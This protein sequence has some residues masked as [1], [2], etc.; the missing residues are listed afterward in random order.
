[1]EKYYQ[2][3]LFGLKVK[4]MRNR[5]NLSFLE[6]SKL[7]DMSVSYL[8]EIEKGKKFPKKD[9][10]ECLAQALGTSPEQLA[11][12][13]LDPALHPVGEL[14]RSNFLSELP[15]DI[16]GIE[17]Q[18]V[19]EI[20]SRA[21]VRVGAFISTLVELSKN[22]A[23]GEDNFY[24]GAMRAY[25][26]L[27]LNYF[28]DIETAAADFCQK[29]HLGTGQIDSRILERILLH[30]YGC[31]VDREELPTY[32][33]LDK[34]YSVYIPNEQ[35]L[36]LQADLPEDQLSLMLGREL[37]H[38][39]LATKERPHHTPLRNPQSFE[40]VLSN[41]RAT[42]F[43]T[44]LM[45]PPKEV[46]RQVEL[47]CAQ[48]KWDGGKLVELMEGYNVSPEMFVHRLTNIM[49]RYFQLK[50]LY[51]IRTRTL[52][53]SGSYVIDKVLHLHQSHHPHSNKIMEH[54]CR[55]WLAITALEELQALRKQGREQTI[56]R[57]QRSR[58]HGTPDEYL[59]TTIAI[60]GEQK[61]TSVTFGILM[62]DWL[63]KVVR[64]SGD[65]DI[66]LREV[67]TTCERCPIPNCP[68]R[69]ALPIVHEQRQAQKQTQRKLEELIQR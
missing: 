9:K 42:Y 30:Q 26:E 29:Q 36:L 13:E 18:K 22:Y 10:L 32:P 5:K 52:H 23:L 21:P 37:G 4:E 59:V 24:F 38:R 8:N 41:F 39:I 43:A 65:A 3:I 31:A 58:Y 35:K 2:R 28:E 34:V 62:D 45:M 25:Q 53:G 14:L 17:L 11:N 66:P 56:A 48:E 68:E 63:R 16:F 19:V 33:E 54:Y 46:V 12:A 60:P 51:F 57:V 20:I 69:A 61:D 67:G 44:A 40:P 50:Q 1:M 15:L 47:F 64:Y 6:L 49:P 27:H 7:A 55:R